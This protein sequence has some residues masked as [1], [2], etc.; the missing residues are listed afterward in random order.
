MGIDGFEHRAV[1]DGGGV[2][3]LADARREVPDIPDV[4]DLAPDLVVA[5]CAGATDEE[6]TH[7]VEGLVPRRVV[8]S[9]L[10]A[11][12][13]SDLASL[14]G[15]LDLVALQ[16]PGLSGH[17]S[18]LSEAEGDPVDVVVTDDLDGP[19]TLIAHDLQRLVQHLALDAADL[20]D[21]VTAVDLVV[22]H[23]VLVHGSNTALDRRVV[24]GVDVSI[25]GPELISGVDGTTPQH[26][27][28]DGCEWLGTTKK[29]HGPLLCDS[30]TTSVEACS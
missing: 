7:V 26:I 28:A 20:D 24:V 27:H 2:P 15:T 10:A 11:N 23:Q 16:P 13:A 21:R 1:V 18:L 14:L 29:S 4:G 9:G 30:G 19:A 12:P 25:D 5:P 6:G 22:G 17:G 8:P 3:L